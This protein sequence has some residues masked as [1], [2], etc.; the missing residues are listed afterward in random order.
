ME[1]L[2]ISPRSIETLEDGTQVIDMT[3]MLPRDKSGYTSFCFGYIFGK[4]Y[5]GNVHHAEIMNWLIE[6]QGKTWEEMFTAEQRWGWVYGN[7][8]NNDVWKIRFSTD[9][10]L[11]T[12]G[13]GEKVLDIFNEYFTEVEITLDGGLEGFTT[14]DNY[15]TRTRVQYQGEGTYC[16]WCDEYVGEDHEHEEYCENCGD[17]YNA[18]DSSETSFHQ[19]DDNLCSICDKYYTSCVGY[20]HEDGHPECYKCGEHYDEE[21][22]TDTAYHN[23][24]YC[25]TDD[26]HY[27]P[28]TEGEEHRFHETTETGL[29]YAPLPPGSTT[30]TTTNY[31]QAAKNL[32]AQFVQGKPTHSWIPEGLAPIQVAPDART[33]TIRALMDQFKITEEAA[34]QVVDLAIAE[35]GQQMNLFSKTAAA[36]PSSGCF[37]FFAGHLIL[38][39]KHHQQI[40]AKLLEKG[41]DWMDMFTQPQAWGWYYNAYP[42]SNMTIRF[43]SDAGVQN[44][45]EKEKAK[46]AFKK[47]FKVADIEVEYNE[48]GKSDIEGYGQ[49]LRG[50]ENV[51]NYFNEGSDWNRLLDQVIGEIP[52]PPSKEY[53]PENPPDPELWQWYVETFGPMLVSDYPKS[54]KSETQEW[55]E[56][57]EFGQPYKHNPVP[58]NPE[59]KQWFERTFNKVPQKK[60]K[61]C[62]GQVV[63]YNT[64][65]NNYDP[66][67]VNP[68][69]NA[70]Y[71]IHFEL[72]EGV[73]QDNVGSS[74]AEG[75]PVWDCPVHAYRGSATKWVPHPDG[76]WGSSYDVY[77]KPG[78]Y[79]EAWDFNID[80]KLSKWEDRTAVDRGI[81]DDSDRYVFAKLAA[82]VLST[83]EDEELLDIEANPASTEYRWSY[84]G[85]DLHIWQVTNRRQYGPSHYDMFGSEGYQQHSQGRV[86]VSPDGKVGSLYWQIS[87]PEC[88]DVINQ[89]IQQTFGKPP[90]Y[91]YRAYGP[92][93]G[94][95]R[96]RMY[97][98]L[99]D[100]WSL[101]FKPH[102][103]YWEQGYT[104]EEWQN[105]P[106]K[107]RR[108]QP[109]PYV[110]P[111]QREPNWKRNVPEGVNPQDWKNMNKKQRRRLRRERRNKGKTR[112]RGRFRMGNI[113]VITYEY[114]RP[115][116]QWDAVVQKFVFDSEGNI[117]IA[118]EPDFNIYG[119]VHHSD[120]WG[121]DLGNLIALGMDTPNNGFLALQDQEISNYKLRSGD[122]WFH[123]TPTPDEIKAAKAAFGKQVRRVRWYG[124]DNGA[125]I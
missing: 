1:K 52:E 31:I 83:G 119:N 82:D 25:S 92:Y 63:I 42:G 72:P 98:P 102:E 57:T 117:I 101:P 106:K 90:D 69:P 103:K 24:A 89:W 35:Q 125:P 64:L 112:G 88:E 108:Q 65:K 86:Y 66:D 51:E 28:E 7:Y 49:G 114:E 95:V 5:L 50:R 53:V 77:I 17:Y 80:T 26:V 10:A 14:Q 81:H 116:E 62:N 91:V 36:L 21:S 43:T 6:D 20:N 11:Q 46:E 29:S 8:G 87:H 96:G 120:L 79:N 9:D 55:F 121:D 34:A 15:G 67:A 12:P 48:S 111:S 27:D 2:A 44:E 19:D 118:D 104:K 115:W 18:M 3:G 68:Y 75:K 73:S 124:I 4:L 22:S 70:Y 56:T 47:L 54:P 84:D 122:L 93:P 37:G 97:Y 23:Q 58:E 38:G 109:A 39:S 78:M 71:I 94:E 76:H 123:Q 33:Q 100:V 13:L 99:V 85:H 74:D 110:A 41:W 105:Q 59:T 32:Y 16:E 113:N 107:K 40:M 61:L 60:P 45:E 30:D